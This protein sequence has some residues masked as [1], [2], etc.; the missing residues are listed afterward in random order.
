M[1]SLLLGHLD[2]AG[3]LLSCACRYCSATFE[4]LCKSEEAR[5]RLLDQMNMT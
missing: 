1:S 2:D 3:K 5:D 4:N